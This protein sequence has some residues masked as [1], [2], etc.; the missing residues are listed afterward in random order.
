MRAFPIVLILGLALSACAT[1]SE[2]TA[3][4]SGVGFATSASSTSTAPVAEGDY[5]AALYQDIAEGTQ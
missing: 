1:V 2:R 5:R 4:S 3:R